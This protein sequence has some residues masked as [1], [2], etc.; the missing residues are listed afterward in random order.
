MQVLEAFCPRLVG[1]QT[2]EETSHR[3]YQA[4]GRIRRAAVIGGGDGRALIAADGGRR[5]VERRCGRGGRYG[6]RCRHRQSRVGIGECHRSAARRRNLRQS[7]GASAGGILA[8]T[9]GIADQRGHRHRRYQADGRIRRGAVIGGGDGR[10]LVAADSGR[11]GVEVAAVA[12]AATVTDAGTVRVA[13][14]LV[15]VTAAPPVGAA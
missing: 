8:Q 2:S 13:L 3:R 15:R 6:D 9:G 1:L 10:A 11:R 4:D 5:R 12:V 14:V 7:H